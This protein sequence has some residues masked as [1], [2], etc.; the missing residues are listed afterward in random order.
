LR[1][2]NRY[3]YV[4]VLPHGLRH[5]GGHLC[6]LQKIKKSEIKK[7]KISTCI[8]AEFVLQNLPKKMSLAGI[9]C[10]RG[11]FFD[12]DIVRQ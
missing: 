3:G 6:F 8:R 1:E 4:R 2:I 12:F 9:E 10:L 11:L 7:V 5:A